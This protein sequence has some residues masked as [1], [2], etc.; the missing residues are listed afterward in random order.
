MLL[1]YIW[2]KRYR[3][4]EIFKRLRNADIS[5]ASNILQSLVREDLLSKEQYEQL[6]DLEELD[7]DT[8]KDVIISSK[9]GQGVSFL[10][11]TLS[12][13]RHTLQSL[14]KDI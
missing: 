10:P 7:Q 8:L 1:G 3:V 11:R 13:L 5:S 9:I 14:L 12:S 4:E 6:A 2:K